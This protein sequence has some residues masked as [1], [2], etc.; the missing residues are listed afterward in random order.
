MLYMHAPAPAE[1]LRGREQG[2]ND[3]LQEI[4]HATQPEVVCNLASP[5]HNP[6][7]HCMIVPDCIP[8]NTAVGS[9]QDTPFEKRELCELS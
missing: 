9:V 2:P 1:L 7:S 5:E 3:L 4:P 6:D 8:E